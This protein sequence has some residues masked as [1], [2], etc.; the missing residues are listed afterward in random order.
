[1]KKLFLFLV[2]S[3]SSLNIMSQTILDAILSRNYLYGE[4]DGEFFNA[5][6]LCVLNNKNEKDIF[7]L[8]LYHFLPSIND[9]D[10]N[11]NKNG[12]VTDNGKL[13]LK[14]NN[15]SILTLNYK[16]EKCKYYGID[17]YNYFIMTLTNINENDIINI[18]NIGVKKIRVSTNISY[19]DL[20]TN[21]FPKIK[22]CYNIIEEKY[23]V[24]NMSKSIY[25]NF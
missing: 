2:F 24:A 1:M 4:E 13:L 20:K 16:N 18:I 11:N 8:S 25:D 14:L 7:T 9:K 12:I 6:M 23:K 22:E 5:K 10:T 19:I 15:D 17:G 21:I 3:I